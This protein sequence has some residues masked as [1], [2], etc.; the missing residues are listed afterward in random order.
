M[1]EQVPVEVADEALES[2]DDI[3][4]RVLGDAG[5]TKD[6]DEGFQDFGHSH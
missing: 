4:E 2:G 6:G 1:E 3:G 5:T